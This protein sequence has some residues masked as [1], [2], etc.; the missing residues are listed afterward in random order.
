MKNRIPVMLVLFLLASLG[1][2]PVYAAENVRKYDADAQVMV[3]SSGRLVTAQK[4]SLQ[5]F[6]QQG[7]LTTNHKL[8]GNQMVA[9]P[10]AGEVVG[11][12]RYNDH[13]PTT[14]KPAAFELF[15]FSGKRIYEIKR[16]RF[17][18]VF[19]APSGTAMVGLDGVEGLPKSQLRFYDA[20]GQEIDSTSVEYFQGGRF[21]TDGSVYIFATAKDGILAFSATGKPVARYGRG[22]VYDLS[23]DGQVFAVAEDGQLRVYS[24]GKRVATMVIDPQVRV[25]SVSAGGLYVAWAG[26]AE[27]GLYTVGSDSALCEIDLSLPGENFR[28]L[29]ISEGDR[30]LAAG[31]DVDP[32]KDVSPE[33]RHTE[34]RVVVYNFSGLSVYERTLT[35]K[36]WGARLPRVKFLNQ[37]GV[38]AVIT[39]EETRFLQL[40][41]PT[42]R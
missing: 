10:E 9:M 16:P 30:Y 39:R 8:R 4:R 32:G 6:D 29:A 41:T 27:A 20:Q 33:L 15:D 23:A 24:G 3:H 21:S 12:L 38:L 25:V 2:S 11:V 31:I 36:K 5:F 18:S 34:G 26:A 19:V 22:S 7:K 37:A 35:Y 17:T 28:S 42:R 1:L 40:P 14:I 13:S